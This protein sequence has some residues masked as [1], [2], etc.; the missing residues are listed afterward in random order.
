MIHG[1]K[2]RDDVVGVICVGGLVTV[3]AKTSVQ[4]LGNLR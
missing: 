1:K 4:G 3:I 2:L